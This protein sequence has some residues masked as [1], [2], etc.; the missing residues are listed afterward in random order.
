MA[1]RLQS[2][3]GKSLIYRVEVHFASGHSR[4]IE[5]N[6]YLTASSPAITLDVAGRG[7]RAI[8][9]VTVVGRNARRSA[10]RV[11]AI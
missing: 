9:H 7:A 8:T 11:L 5:V 10:F 3:A 4:V 2:T 6:R 1:L